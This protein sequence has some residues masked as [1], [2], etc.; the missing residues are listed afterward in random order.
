MAPRNRNLSEKNREENL[1]F[2]SHIFETNRKSS[3]TPVEETQR[4]T[5]LLI[6]TLAH[7]QSFHSQQATGERPTMI[8]SRVRNQPILCST[9]LSNCDCTPVKVSDRIA[10]FEEK[11]LASTFHDSHKTSEGITVGNLLA[12]IGQEAPPT[13]GPNLW[14]CAFEWKNR[15]QKRVDERKTDARFYSLSKELD[16]LD[17]ILYSDSTLLE[18]DAL[19][20][21]SCGNREAYDHHKTDDDDD[22]GDDDDDDDDAAYDDDDAAYDEK[23]EEEEVEDYDSFEDLPALESG[24][25]ELAKELEDFAKLCDDIDTQVKH[26]D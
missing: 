24:A 16:L 10:F 4:N 19:N 1:E 9:A 5:F 11:A 3:I 20:I 23:E 26:V 17:A 2:S 14:R 12:S 13:V 6:L 15:L 25:L 21:I 22:D 18:I 8:A 7:F